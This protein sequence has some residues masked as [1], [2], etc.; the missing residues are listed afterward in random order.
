MPGLNETIKMAVDIGREGYE[1]LLQLLPVKLVALSKDGLSAIIAHDKYWDQKGYRAAY[2][3]FE[4]EA[5]EGE[6]AEKLLT[7]AVNWTMQWS[8]KNVTELL[9]NLV[10]VPR[11]LAESFKAKLN[12]LP[13]KVTFSDGLVLVEEG[14]T[15]VMVNTS[16]A[17][18]LD[19]VIAHPT[20]EKVNITVAGEAEIYMTENVTGGLTCVT[21]KVHGAGAVKLEVKADPESSLNPAYLTVKEVADGTPPTIG[22]PSQT[23]AA[24]NVQPNQPVKVSVNVTDPESGVKNFTLWYSINGEGN[25]AIPMIYNGSTGLWEA[26]IPGQPLDTHVKYWI[27]AYDN[28]GNRAINDNAGQYYTYTVIPEFSSWPLLRWLLLLLTLTLLGAA[29]KVRIR[30]GTPLPYY[31]KTAK[32]FTRRQ[33]YHFT[34]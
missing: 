6:I 19:V 34:R 7:Q 21:L 30:A 27:E 23:P 9:G 13:G 12:E 14:S 3:A 25:Q 28:A 1:K 4:A 2:F 22:E 8:F 20:S 31:V 15:T 16:G 10:R 17:G 29:M 24:N 18:S 33:S 26:E 5:V 11:E 32:G